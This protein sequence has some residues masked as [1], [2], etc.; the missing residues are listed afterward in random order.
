M[1]AS[2]GLRV[3]N[4]ALLIV[5]L[6]AMGADVCVLPMHAHASGSTP[7]PTTADTH[8]HDDGASD[9][10]LH[11]ASCEALRLVSIDVTPILAAQ[12]FVSLEIA[13]R[14]ALAAFAATIPLSTASPPLFL[15]H[16][17]LLI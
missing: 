3:R 14:L 12:P 16:V 10:A 15:L 13:P 9:H 17:S 6:F 5:A 1:R 8:H 11:T 7:V 2:V 4:V